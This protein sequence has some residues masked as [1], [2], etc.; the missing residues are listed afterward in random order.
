MFDRTPHRSPPPPPITLL[1]LLCPP[2]PYLLLLICS[3]PFHDSF[4]F[5]PCPDFL[6]HSSL[7][8]LCSLLPCVLCLTLLISPSSCI[9]CPFIYLLPFAFCSFCPCQCLCEFYANHCARIEALRRR[10]QEE[11]TGRQVEHTATA[12]PGVVLQLG[13]NLD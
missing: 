13:C 11:Q 2:C 12:G 9:F 6:S 4:F 1:H 5:S 3:I 10:L 7:C 8:T